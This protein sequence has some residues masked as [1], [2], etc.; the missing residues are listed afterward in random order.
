VNFAMGHSFRKLQAAVEATEI[1]RQADCRDFEKNGGWP[2]SDKS[3]AEVLRMC[4]HFTAA[5]EA[6]QPMARVTFVLDEEQEAT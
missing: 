5:H 6:S 1:H 4:S 2:P 3:F